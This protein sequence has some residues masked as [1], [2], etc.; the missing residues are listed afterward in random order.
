MESEKTNT[1][2]GALAARGEPVEMAERVAAFDWERTAL[3]PRNRWPEALRVAV[4]LCLQCRFGMHVWWGP[5]LI[6]IY[7]D[8]HIP[9]LG[10]RH[11]GALGLSARVVWADVWHVLEGEVAAVTERGESTWNERR[12]VLLER[13]GALTDAWFTWS[14]S[15]IRDAA[16]KVMGLMCVSTEDTAQILAERER[17]R[18]EES[19]QR[20][21]V[22][23]RA[24]AE[25]ALRDSKTLLQ[26]ISD[27]TDDAIFA[28]D[29][30]G[31]LRF[32]NP[33]TLVLIGK[34]LGEV[35][36]KTDADVLGDAATAQVVMETD[37]RI[38][39]SGQGED[40]EEV[41][42]LADGTRRVWFSRKIPFRDAAGKVVGLVGISRDISERKAIEVEMMRAKEAAEA[43]SKAK[44]Q[45]LAVVSHELRTPLNPIMAITSYLQTRTDLPEELQEDLATIRRSV[46]QEVRIIEDLLSLTRL[47]RGKVIL[48]QEAVDLHAMVAESI[49][50]FAQRAAEKHVSL[51]AELGA[52]EHLIWA[53]PSR[54]RQVLANLLDNAVKFTPEGG[55]VTVRTLDAD[56]GRVRIELTDTGAGIEPDVLPR[57]FTP[58]EQGEKT[59]TRRFGGLGLGLVIVKGILDL[60][61]GTVTAYSEGRDKG[62]TLVVELASM[63]NLAATEPPTAVVLNE[64]SPGG[65]RILLVEDHADTLQIMSR[66]LK[67][68]GY[69]VE[70]A[71]TVKEAMI[72]GQGAFD[73]LVSDIGLPDGSGLDIMRMMRD[74]TGLTGIAVSGFGHDDDVRRSKEAGFAVHLVKPV[75]FGVLDG[76][77]KQLAG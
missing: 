69:S 38:M 68:L 12:H 8:A 22:E 41:V 26:G 71:T 50:H 29:R 61:K 34:P 47:Q 10:S 63:R 39:D 58:F 36:G 51:T 28:K 59:I 74:R 67:S 1:P 17:D 33:A 25:E 48:H 46:E 45:L 24:R 76:T 40:I 52:A 43:A 5:E 73:V 35:L 42:P 44:D 6:N 27:S 66:V 14:Y 15:P 11:P 54:M 49:Q 65:K 23:E 77:L 62:T 9:L 19:R 57:L 13:E 7:N 2:P 32:A 55:R 75:D 16:G 3:G 37:R 21:R 56:G 30:A 31:R 72:K 64:A 70:T 53:D 4:D 60:H 18:L 20:M